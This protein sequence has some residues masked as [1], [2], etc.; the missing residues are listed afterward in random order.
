MPR[1]GH[2]RHAQLAGRTETP[3]LSMGVFSA[4]TRSQFRNFFSGRRSEQCCIVRRH[5]GEE[6]DAHPEHAVGL[7]GTEGRV[8]SGIGVRRKML[9]AMFTEAGG[10][11][12]GGGGLELE[13]MPPAMAGKAPATGAPTTAPPHRR[14]RPSTCGPWR[15]ARPWRS[16]WQRGDFSADGLFDEDNADGWSELLQSSGAAR[17]GSRFRSR[18]LR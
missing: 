11:T 17:E 12:G 15:P 10:G 14:S 7:T 16:G 9:E 2:D 8:P 6:C 5:S 4:N 3:E 13:A 1:T 18:V